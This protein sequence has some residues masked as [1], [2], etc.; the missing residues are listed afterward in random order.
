MAALRTALKTV[1]AACHCPSMNDDTARFLT[2]RLTGWFDDED[3]LFDDDPDD[4]PPPPLTLSPRQQAALA[5]AI[6]A[7]L[8]EN[9]CDNTLRAAQ[10]WVDQAGLDWST[11]A[12]ALQG[13]GGYCDCEVLLNVE[14]VTS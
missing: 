10:R 14:L 4:L 13:R 6:E 7:G 2:R 12:A 9:G 8:H 5:A 11:V 3:L 1:G